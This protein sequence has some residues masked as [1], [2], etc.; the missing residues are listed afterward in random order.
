[1]FSFLFALSLSS[2]SP[3]LFLSFFLS[4]HPLSNSLTVVEVVALP[5]HQILVHE[6]DQHRRRDVPGPR[7]RAGDGLAGEAR[8]CGRAAEVGGRRRDPAGVVVALLGQGLI[9][10][11]LVVWMGESK[12]RKEAS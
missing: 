10:F 9:V 1:M 2:S 7:G 6:D 8:R 12:G 3:F 5:A 4:S 11:F